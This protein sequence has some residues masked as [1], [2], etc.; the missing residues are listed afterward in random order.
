MN[1][2]IP[3]A[4]IRDGEH[5]GEFVTFRDR[6]GVATLHVEDVRQPA[7]HLAS[8]KF[9]VLPLCQKD[10]VD[11][12]FVSGQSGVGKSYFIAQYAKNYKRLFP[13]NNVYVIS[14]HDDDPTLDKKIPGLKRLKITEE[15]LEVDIDITDFADS[16][17]IMDDYDTVADKKLYA[18]LSKLRD[19]ILQN[20]RH[21]RTYMCMVS[22]QILD[23]KKTRMLLL[24]S[25]KVVFFC[26]SGQY[27]IR[28]FLKQYQ[29]LD[30]DQIN[31][32]MKL[33]SRWCCL[34]K[35]TYPNVLISEK[36][37]FIL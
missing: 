1:K 11:R 20:G 30:K 8:G 27:Q 15:L 12:L 22:H 10:Q 2:E 32:I 28:N 14:R 23:Y 26:R 7:L 33:P 35:N 25:T 3:V 4:V 36:T 16:L 24:E 6:N 21:H 37:M 18:L 13:D 9:E 17:L 19:D 34:V 29:S 31:T 5:D